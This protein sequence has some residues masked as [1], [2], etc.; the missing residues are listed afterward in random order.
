MG[1]RKW[2]LYQDALVPR[3]CEPRDRSSDDESMPASEGPPAGLKI[4]TIEQI[5]APENDAGT[6]R[7]EPETNSQR[8]HTEGRT[9]T[10]L[11]SLIKR[12]ATHP[13]VDYHDEPSDWKP[14]DKCYFCVDGEARGGEATGAGERT[15]GGGATVST[16]HL[17]I[18][19][20]G[21]VSAMNSAPVPLRSVL[22]KL[23]WSHVMNVFRLIKPFC[24]SL[25]S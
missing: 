15:T 23:R 19:I 3:R 14:A 8:N 22:R 2:K 24:R 10:I 18:R 25:Y 5:N 9:E 20:F 17:L 4:K 16:A 21:K 1:R 12:P 6:P 13:K 7:V 11:E